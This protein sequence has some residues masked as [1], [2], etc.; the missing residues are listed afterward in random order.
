MNLAAEV[1]AIFLGACVCFL[2]GFLSGMLWIMPTRAKYDHLAA[3]CAELRKK[4]GL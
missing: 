4:V 2:M 1:S 3:E